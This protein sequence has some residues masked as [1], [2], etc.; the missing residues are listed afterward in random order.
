MSFSFEKRIKEAV[1]DGQRVLNTR[2]AERRQEISHRINATS[3]SFRSLYQRVRRPH[4]NNL[5]NKTPSLPNCSS[6][7]TTV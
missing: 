7:Y 2:A 5:K 1:R 6:Q 4:E 3:Q